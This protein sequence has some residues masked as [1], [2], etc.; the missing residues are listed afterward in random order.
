MAVIEFENVMG[1]GYE[2]RN[3]TIDLAGVEVSRGFSRQPAVSISAINRKGDAVAGHL[4][5]EAASC[6]K[7]AR[8]IAVI[9]ANMSPE[10][11]HEIEA[12]LKAALVTLQT[13]AEMPLDDDLSDYF[14]PSP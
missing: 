12:E 14:A 6:G 7:I 1:S 11:R 3:G 10:R 13:M 8:E 9:G 5:L 2:G 4:Y